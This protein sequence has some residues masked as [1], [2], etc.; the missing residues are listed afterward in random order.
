MAGETGAELVSMTG[1]TAESTVKVFVE[2]LRFL[3][4]A[5]RENYE[6]KLRKTTL[7]DNRLKAERGIVSTDELVKIA[8]LKNT[9]VNAL[10]EKLSRKQQDKFIEYAKSMGIPC[11]IIMKNYKGDE[12]RECESRIRELKKK[13]EH[14]Q[15]AE[16]EILNRR[17]E[18]CQEVEKSG[19]VYS[20]KVLKD[21]DNQL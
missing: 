16:K 15:T 21:F 1:R 18:Y 17:T 12:I 5:K 11:S 9:A 13:G 6:K 3:R 4:E 10:P 2:R 20:D 14:L 19:G 8:N 7:N